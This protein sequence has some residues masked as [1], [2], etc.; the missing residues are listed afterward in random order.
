MVPANV[1]P[2]WEY[3]LRWTSIPSR[4]S[5]N[6]SKF[7]SLAACVTFGLMPD[8]SYQL[9]KLKTSLL[10]II[11]NYKLLML[12]FVTVFKYSFG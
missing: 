12:Q 11:L 3:T 2:G 4:G 5:R 8:L 7:H 1:K 6:A 10:W 9:K